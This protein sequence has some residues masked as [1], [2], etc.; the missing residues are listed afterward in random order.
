MTSKSADSQILDETV[1]Q[2][3]DT[4][5]ALQDN[6]ESKGNNA[7]YFAHATKR[8]GP[9]WDGK[10]QPRLL[11][12][13]HDADLAASTSEL[14]VSMEET[15]TLLKSLTRG[16]SSFDFTKSTITKYAFLDEGKKV[17]IYVELPGVGDICVNNDDVKLQWEERSFSLVVNNYRK[18]DPV[19]EEETKADANDEAKEKKVDGDLQCLCFGKLHGYITKASFKKKMDRIIITLVK[20][21]EEGEEEAKEWPT[22]G[23]KGCDDEFEF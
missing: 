1:P 13:T 15:K 7:Y 4:K 3:D 9:K 11:S 8:N 5:S 20:K 17:K 22:V 18:S 19:E 6:I 12:P 16:K 14:T 23:A 21:L 10:P 2:N